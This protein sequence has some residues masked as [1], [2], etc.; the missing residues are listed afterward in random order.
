M[1]SLAK[2]IVVAGA[3]SFPRQIHEEDGSEGGRPLV[4]AKEMILF[5]LMVRCPQLIEVVD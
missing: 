4:H 1:P 2:E 3:R 5:Q